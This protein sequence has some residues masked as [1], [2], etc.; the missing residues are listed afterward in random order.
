MACKETRLCEINIQ[1]K[2][3]SRDVAHLLFT[4]ALVCCPAQAGPSLRS[5]AMSRP[6]LH[7][8]YNAALQQLKRFRSQHKAFATAYIAAQ[9]KKGGDEKGT[10]GSDFVPALAA[11]R[12]TTARFQ[13]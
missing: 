5:I 9:A 11:Y 12:D 6:E 7:G 3:A 13:I 10:G 1:P 8:P 2:Q 4:I